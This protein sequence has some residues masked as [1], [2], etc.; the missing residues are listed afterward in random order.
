MKKIM[1]SLLF[2]TAFSIGMASRPVTAAPGTPIGPS[3]LPC[4]WN[5]QLYPHGAY[6]TVTI[7]GLYG[8]IIRYDV[9]QCQNTKWVYRYSSDDIN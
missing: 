5:G 9:Y 4:R 6:R 2:V 1:L 3:P 8:E 7:T